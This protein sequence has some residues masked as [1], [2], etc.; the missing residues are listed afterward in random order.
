M[1]AKVATIDGRWST[2]GSSNIDPFS[3]LVAREANLFVR[4]M[5]FAALLRGDLRRVLHEH[6]VKIQGDDLRRVGLL[7]QMAQWVC[8]G[9]VRLA[10]SL[11]GYG[12]SRNLE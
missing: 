11:S 3:L 8:Y 1:H 4:D 5:S 12:G 10:M 6:A 2:V 7:Q 9:F